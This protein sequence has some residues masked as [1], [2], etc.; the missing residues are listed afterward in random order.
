M[1]VAMINYGILLQENKIKHRLQ[2]NIAIEYI[3]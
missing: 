2:I 3:L 1:H